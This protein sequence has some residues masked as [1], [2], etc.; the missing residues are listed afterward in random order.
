MRSTLSKNYHDHPQDRS[1]KPPYVSLI[2]SWSAGGCGTTALGLAVSPY[3][4]TFFQKCSDT[5]LRVMHNSVG[6]HNIGRLGIGLLGRQFSLF[7]ERPFANGY[8]CCRGTGN[9]LGNSRYG[10]V[11]LVVGYHMRN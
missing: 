1:A 11:Q 9:L 5:F 3:W 7:I 10:G 6:G 2:A 4:V 8:G